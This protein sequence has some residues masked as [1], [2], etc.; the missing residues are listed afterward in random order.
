MNTWKRRLLALLSVPLLA[1]PS[2]VGVYAY[3]EP[4]SGWFAAGLAAAGFEVLYVG[5]NVLIISSPELRRYARNVSVGAVVTAVL[6]N[7]IAHY[8]APTFDVL[9]LFLSLIASAPL[10]TL[11]YAVSVLLHRLSEDAAR[12]STEDARLHVSLAQRDEDIARLTTNL[13]QACEQAAQV[14]AASAQ[15]QAD[16]E[17]SARGAAHQA[18]ELAQALR[19]REQEIAQLREQS[20]QPIAIDGIDLLA[21]ARKL[22]NSDVSL[23]ETADL[24]RVPES[25]LRSRLKTGANG[26]HE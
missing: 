6:M 24:L 7:T 23:R 1:V 12:H 16:L 8:S 2:A 15:R 19:E 26:V 11:A 10:A 22:R 3:L 5:V 25:T 21:V 18:R 14:E 17:R 20:A 4:E 13:A 9:E